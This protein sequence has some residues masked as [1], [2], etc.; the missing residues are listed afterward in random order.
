[1][2]SAN[3]S[4]AVLMVPDS[5]ADQI[6]TERRRS[7]DRRCQGNGED[8]GERVAAAAVPRRPRGDIVDLLPL[9]ALLRAERHHG[10]GGEPRG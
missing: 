6:F 3:L 10:G 7:P 5:P 4:D 1:V 9:L 2:Q 8:G